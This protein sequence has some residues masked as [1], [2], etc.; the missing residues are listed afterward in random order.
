MK[1][2]KGPGLGAGR[3]P[4]KT[5][6][7]D[8]SP[9]TSLPPLVEGHLHCFLKLTISEVLWMV[10]KPPSCA[11]IRVRW[12]GE[13][14]DGT[15]FCPRD[16][17][18]SEQK[19]VRTTTRY[20]VRC[21]PKQFSAY[22]TDMAILVLEVFSKPDH[23]PIGS[24]QISGLSQLSPNHP[25]DGFFTIVSPASEKLGELQVS[26]A[27]E[28]LSEMYGSRGS[29]P[30][31]DVSVDGPLA[32][33]R[34]RGKAEPSKT[35][36]LVP[37]Q[38][39]RFATTSSALKESISSSRATTP[40]QRDYLYVQEISDPTKRP[41]FGPPP[42]LSSSQAG[43]G[44]TRKPAP[45][46]QPS[47]PTPAEHPTP[48]GRAPDWCGGSRVP[49]GTSPAT[50][51]LLS[52]LLEQGNKLRNAMVVSAMKSC[53]DIDVDLPEV[54]LSSKNSSSKASAKVPVPFGGLYKDFIVPEAEVP[55]LPPAEDGFWEHDPQA[56]ANAIQLLLGS[57]ELAHGHGWAGVGSPPNSLSP[58]SEL[59]CNSELNDPQYD[60][61]LLENL[62]YTA[63]KSDVS[64]SD[65][66]NEDDDDTP[67]KKIETGGF[68]RSVNGL[69]S[70]DRGQKKMAA[71]KKLRNF[72]VGRKATSEIPE[73]TQLTMLGVDRLALLG[74]IH[75]ARVIIET[76]SIPP[77][78]VPASLSPKSCSGKPP[79]PTVAKKR[80]FFVEYRFPVRSSRDGTG[81]TSV[82]VEIV[83]LASRK[84]AGGVVKFQQRFVFP[85]HF[86]GA[87]IEHWWN[88][89]LTFKIFLR[90]NTEKKPGTIGSASLPLRDILQSELLSFSGELHV[91]EEDGQ[92]Q[93]GPLKISV[94]LV[95]NN[96]DFTDVSAK[97]VNDHLQS[98]VCPETSP[99]KKSLEAECV[100][101]CDRSPQTLPQKPEATSEESP[102]FTP[103]VF[104]PPFSEAKA[105]SHCPRGQLSGTAEENGLLLHVLLMVPDGKDFLSGSCEKQRPCNV[106]LKCKLFNTEEAT[107]SSVVWGT[108][109]PAFHFSQVTP[110]SLSPKHLERLKNNVMVIEAWNKVG[111]AGTD[112]LLGLAKLPLHQF[113]LSFRDPKISRLLLKAQYPVVAIDSYVPVI[114]I[115]TGHQNG[116]LRVLL[117]MGS[118]E[119]VMALQRLKN[120]EETLP[121]DPQRPAHCLDR[122][123]SPVTTAEFQRD[124][125]VEH[126]FEVHVEKVKGLAPLQST[127]WGEADCYVQYYFP[128]QETDSSVLKGTE[129]IESGTVLKPRRSATTLCVPDPIFNDKQL[130]T[131][132]V[133][134]GM[135]LQR[136]LLCAF[137]TPG[138]AAGVGVQFEIW[139]RYYYPNVRDQMVAKATLPLSRLC[140]LVTM[141]HSGDVGIQTFSLPLI[142]WTA[143]MEG[144]QP[145]PSGVLDVSLRYRQSLKTAEGVV[146]A[147]AV[148]ISVHVRRAAGLQAAARRAAEETPSLRSSAEVGINASVAVHFSFL[149]RGE[150]RRTCPVAQTFCP[151]FAYHLEFPCNLAIQRGGGETCF[152]AELLEFGEVTFSVYHQEAKAANEASRM[153]PPRDYLLGV[154][155]VPTRD[156]LIRRSGISGWHPVTLPED[157]ALPSGTGSLHS[158]VGGLELSVAFSRRG[159]RERVVDAARLAGRSRGDAPGGGLDGSLDGGPRG[160]WG[161]AALSVCTPKAWL[162]VHCLLRAGQNHV[163]QN[164]Y[165][166]LRY[167]LYDQEGFWTPLA[168][169]RVT[170]DRRHVSLRFEVTRSVRVTRSQSLLWYFREER[171]EVQLWHALGDDSGERPRDTDRW[172]GSAYVDLSE[173][174]ERPAPVRTVC[175]VYPLFRRNADDLS[176]AAVRVR[177]TL[178]S[179]V[180]PNS[181][182][183]GSDS[184]GDGSD[185]DSEVTPSR[186][187]PASKIL[188]V[189]KD[190]ASPEMPCGPPAPDPASA[191]APAHLESTFAV[192][193]LVERALHLSLKGSPLTERSVAS[194]SCCVSFVA[195]EERSPIYTPVVENTDS[196]VWDFEQQTRLP[197]ELL[198]DPRQALV[199][200]VWHKTDVERVIGFASVD[201]SPLLSGF[202]FIC[203]WY[204]ITDFSGQCQGQIKVAISP[205]ENISHLK[206]ERLA[207]PAPKASGSA[208]Q[209]FGT[210]FPQA[211]T[212]PWPSLPSCISRGVADPSAQGVGFSASSQ[213]SPSRSR[214]ARREEHIQNVRR[215]HESL[216]QVEGS[217]AHGDIRLESLSHSSRSSLRAS[218]RRNL[219]ELDEI[220]R[221]FS[222]KL[223]KPPPGLQG[224]RETPRE[225]LSREEPPPGHHRGSSAPTQGWPAREEPTPGAGR[226]SLDPESRGILE[227]SSHLV[228]HVSALITDLQNMTKGVQDPASL[229]QGT[230]VE[231]LLGVQSPA[232]GEER[233]GW[234]QEEASARSPRGQVPT[235]SP[236]PL[237]SAPPLG[238]G[239][240]EIPDQAVTA[241]SPP[242]L[243]RGPSQPEAVPASS[244][245]EYEEEEII[246]PKTLNEITA[247]TDRTSPW[248]S[249]L[250][251]AEKTAAAAAAA[252]MEGR[253]DPLHPSR[254]GRHEGN[255]PLSRLQPEDSPS[256]LSSAS[257]GA[258]PCTEMGGLGSTEPGVGDLSDG[259]GAQKKDRPEAQAAS[260]PLTGSPGCCTTTE[261]PAASETEQSF[262]SGICGATRTDDEWHGGLTSLSSSGDEGC[263]S[264]RRKRGL[265]IR[266]ETS[267]PQITLPDPI[268]V[269]NFFLPSRQ[270]EASMRLLALSTA[271][272]ELKRS[273]P[274][275]RTPNWSRSRPKPSR[276]PADLPQQEARRIAKIFSGQYSKEN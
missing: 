29:L 152:L 92:A 98:P 106:Y 9:S 274:S 147:R 199:F 76:L 32:D 169:P 170:R 21:G 233:N 261:A 230:A 145:L 18:Q 255:D 124:G 262:V 62:F 231:T 161:P 137:S 116:S 63:P 6:L 157:A 25:I 125:L 120:E 8:V 214:S 206:E 167:K 83:Q 26:L 182:V 164:T 254:A 82:T 203:G 85:V 228:S 59:D 105:T 74:R 177:V 142:P 184:A 109:Q 260:S 249:I 139:C 144:L 197:K 141:Q 250:S 97:L 57:V 108:T 266:K 37:S 211:L 68:S 99:G 71:G 166:Y 195:V 171:L 213:S 163:P 217:G 232:D 136:I 149:P 10:K 229:Q 28:P 31:T 222:R 27:L 5:G 66:L 204:N 212:V 267:R 220:Q 276:A 43:E 89:F 216:Q 265:A 7:S 143:H 86:D 64:V 38:P 244:E 115:F 153:Q 45:P 158:V 223:A 118:A 35:P 193:I 256:G 268:V 200:K 201:L 172:I 104:K 146:A 190:C 189:P 58:K 251:E 128:A 240:F 90:K 225:R 148:F 247:V 174:G 56:E 22:L 80:T 96:K 84:I 41:F 88:S 258:S 101:V 132:L 221:H 257:S 94:A 185:G 23:L 129:L 127:V 238:G 77:D 44:G 187:V 14:S 165:C 215:F 16:S 17:S 61:S 36:V 60:Q 243:T 30:A 275:E 33:R 259:W 112:Q 65:F 53:A 51:D 263:P 241:Q 49:S 121:S 20:A 79:R 246:E 54:Q 180:D 135:P 93:I 134:P 176:G 205:L 75:S 151:E 183:L 103:S 78:G 67:S 188:D 179:R 133:P 130:H 269:P 270:L 123:P 235:P 102:K 119:Q 202:Q 42:Q 239:L 55:F 111:R 113:Y 69:D 40:K 196:P 122:P 150:V 114:D 87:M 81:Q 242:R 186:D 159:D 234:Q 198:L 50:K 173:L 227:K 34:L 207:R 253:G 218:L 208:S 39:S 168:K 175:G 271:P 11:D 140:A 192:N 52:A 126:T 117:A 107:R 47:L 95:V 19:A 178:T 100:V 138:H 13:T 252:A 162:P 70:K 2:R 110:V 156:L 181:P 226:I 15:R 24:V 237:H 272:E 210:L 236:P 273:N 194:P 1:R 154:V 191:P 4:K 245:D 72:P 160:P 3:A 48:T 12:W 155:R 224:G 131:L 264:A 219:R 209:H 46:E 73:E 248:S 91:V